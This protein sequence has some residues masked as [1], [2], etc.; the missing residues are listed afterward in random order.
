[1]L[2]RLKC[3]FNKAFQVVFKDAIS[4]AA[5]FG[6]AQITAFDPAINGPDV[7]LQHRGYFFDCIDIFFEKHIINLAID[8]LQSSGF[9]FFDLCLGKQGRNRLFA[10]GR[11]WGKA[12]FGGGSG[13]MGMRDSAPGEIDHCIQENRMVADIFAL[14]TV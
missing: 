4:L 12:A 5:K 1:M 9:L 6:R 13:G 2:G 10:K 11:L 3:F 7:Y 8:C 14:S